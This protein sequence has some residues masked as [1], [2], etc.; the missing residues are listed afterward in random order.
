M[1][2]SR[3]FNKLEQKLEIPREEEINQ[4][5]GSI[6]KKAEKDHLNC[7]A[8]G[9]ETCREHAIAIHNGLAESEMCLPFSIEKLNRMVTDL[10][11]TNEKLANAKM[12]LKQSEK[13]AN[14]GQL[15]AGIAHELNNP[16]GVI[17]M[18]SNILKEE[19]GQNDEIVDDLNL[20]VEQAERCKNI[21]GGLLN[22]ARKNQVNLTEGDIV[23][24]C[25]HSLDSVIKP[26]NIDISFLSLVKDPVAMFDKDQMMQVLTNLE[27]NAV[28]AMSEGGEL[29]LK[30]KDTDESVYIE[31]SD[32]GEGIKEEDKEKVFTPFFTTKGI[33]K[34]TGMGLPLVYGIIKMHGGQIKVES[35]ADPAKGPTGTTFRIELPRRKLSV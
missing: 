12:E 21:V 9:Y 5:L 2:F 35:N 20:I 28:E 13:L 22:F 11:V 8:C 4:I 23:E 26:N 27:K 25:K 15:S 10:N 34:G 3:S 1:D 24:F 33:G 31:V 19:A 7:G 6:G 16:L 17:T 29:S 14:M 18:Y 32:N 30:L